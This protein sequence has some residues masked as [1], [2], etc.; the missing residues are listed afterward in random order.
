ML[1]TELLIKEEGVYYEIFSR[2]IRVRCPVCRFEAKSK[3]KRTKTFHSLKSLSWHLTHSHSGMVGYPFTT[4]QVL[5]VLRAIG[6]AIHWKIL[7]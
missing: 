2:E 4:D 3:T 5:E 1:N 7:T 6:I